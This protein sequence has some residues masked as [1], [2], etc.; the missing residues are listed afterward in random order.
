MSYQR[1]T[2]QNANRPSRTA[3][4]MVEETQYEDQAQDMPFA[5]DSRGYA[6]AVAYLNVAV[7]DQNGIPHKLG[8][9]GLE[10]YPDRA[11]DAAI[12][13]LLFD[14][15]QELDEAQFD[16]FIQSC[17]FTINIA[18]R[19]VQ[20]VPQFAAASAV[21]EQPSKPATKPRRKPAVSTVVDEE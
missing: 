7:L 16:A 20:F 3:S 10:I 11:V 6:K 18:N 1:P 21:P 4:R 8:R 17:V 2:A 14:E 12:M 13:D 15:N 5:V 19:T 9:R